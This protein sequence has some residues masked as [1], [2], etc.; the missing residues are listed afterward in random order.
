VLGGGSEYVAFES[1]YIDKTIG[2][3][4]VR[5]QLILG[6]IFLCQ[7]ITSEKEDR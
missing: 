7:L 1:I 6:V 3:P 4:V 2:I 5:R